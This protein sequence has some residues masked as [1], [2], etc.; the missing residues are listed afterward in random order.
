MAPQAEYF[1]GRGRKVMKEMK[2]RYGKRGKE[3]FHATANARG[4]TPKSYGT[5]TMPKDVGAARQEEANRIATP[6]CRT[7][8]KASSYLPKRPGKVSY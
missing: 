4:M 8:L 3:V 2:A 6:L 5:M 1:H 7:I